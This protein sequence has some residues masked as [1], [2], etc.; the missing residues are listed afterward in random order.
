MDYGTFYQT[1]RA[2]NE[3]G[4]IETG[5]FSPAAIGAGISFSQQ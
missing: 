5:T 4:Y 3:L 2:A 1:V